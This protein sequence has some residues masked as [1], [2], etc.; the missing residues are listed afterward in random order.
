MADTDWN[1][2]KVAYITGR[3]G[4]RELAQEYDVPLSTLERHGRA[5]KWADLR[6][7]YE[8]KVTANALARAGAKDVDRLKKLQKAGDKMCRELEKLMKDAE[9]QLYTHV[10]LE[11]TG[12]GESTLIA[13]K[14]DV[15]DDRKLLNISR[16]IDTMSR[17]MRNLYDIQTV[18]ER[19]QL[20]IA[21]EELK[22]KKK[23]QKDK[24]EK[25]TGVNKIEIVMPDQLK[26]YVE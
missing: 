26:A 21:K 1:E 7:Q 6:R 12:K 9:E 20:K 23:A 14:L 5:E 11:G 13:R 19:E 18:G 16:S 15:V 2:I 4:Y 17:A 22:I 24:S 25:D 10:A 8:G 3:S